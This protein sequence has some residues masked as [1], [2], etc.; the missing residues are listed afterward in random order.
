MAVIFLSMANVMLIFIVANSNEF[1]IQL[2]IFIAKISKQQSSSNC[3]MYM[4][5]YS[6]ASL[7]APKW[8]QIYRC[9]EY[10]GRQ[11]L[12]FP[13]LSSVI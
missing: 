10:K 8:A 7:N 1:Q 6:V 12:E 13:H 4:H 3:R 11:R 5:F 2:C 9:I